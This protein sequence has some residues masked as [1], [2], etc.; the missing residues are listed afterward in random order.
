MEVMITVSIAAFS[1]GV[2]VGYVAENVHGEIKRRKISEELN[3][4]RNDSF[5]L[6]DAIRMKLDNDTFEKV[7]REYSRLKMREGGVR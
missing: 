7:L 2:L 4:T 5:R 3:R 1:L 6:A